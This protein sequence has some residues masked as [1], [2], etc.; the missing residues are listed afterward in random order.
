MRFDKYLE[1]FAKKLSANRKELPKDLKN[2]IILSNSNRNS[3]GHIKKITF[4]ILSI[5]KLAVSQ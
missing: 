5:E 4:S 3:I 1:M 2:R